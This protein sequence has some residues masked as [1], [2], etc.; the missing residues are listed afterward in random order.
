MSFNFVSFFSGGMGLDIGLE[1]S[2][3]INLL[4]NDI[5][6]GSKKTI[7]FNKPNA[8]FLECSIK[9][10]NGSNVFLMCP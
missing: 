7:E 4:S 3:G 5:C 6:R 2:G 9:S 1:K 10:L 8:K